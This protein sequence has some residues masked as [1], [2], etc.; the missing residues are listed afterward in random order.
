VKTEIYKL[1]N[2]YERKFGA[3]RSQRPAQSAMAS[4]KKKQAWGRIFGGPG[5]SGVVDPSPTSACTS[6]QFAFA[7]GCELIAYLDSDNVTTYEDD[8]DLLL[9][10]CDH[11]LT[12]PILSIM[13]KDI[14]F[15]P[16]STISLESCFSLIGRIIEEW[17]RCLLSET[18]EMLACIKDWELEE[19]RLQYAVDNQ[20]LEDS[21]QNLYLDVDASGAA[22]AGTSRASTSASVASA[23]T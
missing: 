23:G 1:F 2:K 13:A 8:F 15:V 17:R 14:M 20:E 12:F 19:K 11:K 7:A 5:S 21:F 16:I 22:S 18:V 4:G 6:S 9:W 10:W 3:A